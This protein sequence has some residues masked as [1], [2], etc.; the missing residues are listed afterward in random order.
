MG[1]LREVKSHTLFEN[2][3]VVG[4]LKLFDLIETLGE[5]GWLKAVRPAD[6]ALAYRGIPRSSSRFQQVLFSYTEAV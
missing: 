4:Q 6:C 1:R 2:S 5:E 3:I